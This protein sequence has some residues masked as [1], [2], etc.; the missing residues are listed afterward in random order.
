MDALSAI[1]EQELARRGIAFERLDEPDLYRIQTGELTFTA[2]LANRRRDAVRDADPAAMHRF[3]DD[4]LRSMSDALSGPPPWEQARAL[5]YFAAETADSEFG[6][7]LRSAVSDHVV[8]V[9]TLTDELQSR[10]VWVTPSMVR[11]WGLSEDEVIARALANQDELLRGIELKVE[12]VAGHKLGMV[13]L[14]SPYKASVVFAPSFRDFVAPKL[15]WPVL[16]VIPCRDFINVVAEGSE[17]VNRMG[18]VVVEEYQ[19]S[20]YPICTEVLRISD[21]GIEAIGRYSG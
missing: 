18:K 15:G 4:L 13:P 21:D 6:D 5:L 10:I 16:A 7:A 2:S 12:D 11:S 19:K 1:F 17:L 3:V 8:R 9:V 20:G 14:S